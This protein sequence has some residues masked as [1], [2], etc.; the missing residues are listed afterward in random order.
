MNPG[1]RGWVPEVFWT[2]VQYLRIGAQYY[3]FS[4][5]HGASSNYD[6][7]GRNAKDNNTFFL[8]VWGAY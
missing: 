7:A 8:Y 4:R 1:T 3:A 6:G 2:P 5:F